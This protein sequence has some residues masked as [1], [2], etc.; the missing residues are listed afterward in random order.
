MFEVE[1]EDDF[2]HFDGDEW[3]DFEEDG[4]IRPALKPK[5]TS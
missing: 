1:D 5:F 3:S 4:E 2:D